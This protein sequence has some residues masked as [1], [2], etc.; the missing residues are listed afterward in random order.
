MVIKAL[1]SLP[2]TERLTSS[3]NNKVVNILEKYDKSLMNNRNN[4]GPRTLPWG[5]P[6][7]GVLSLD[8]LLS[9][10]VRYDLLHK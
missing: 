10:T 5:T 8:G 1:G 7:R 3:Q 2:E 6:T 9:I 4:R